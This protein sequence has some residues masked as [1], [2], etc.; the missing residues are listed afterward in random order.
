MLSYRLKYANSHFVDNEGLMVNEGDF[1]LAKHV[2]SS[3]DAV[4]VGVCSSSDYYDLMFESDTEFFSCTL[5]KKKFLQSGFS[6]FAFESSLE[7]TS[8]G[9]DPFASSKIFELILLRN[10]TVGSGG[11]E[12]PSNGVLFESLN[13]ADGSYADG[14]P[15]TVIGRDGAYKV[16]ASRNYYYDAKEKQNMLFYLLERTDLAH[17][18]TMLVADVHVQKVV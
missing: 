18:P 15:V 13:G 16:L 11:G 5:D 1:Y 12:T 4:V 3:G 9:F 14:T 7:F 10:S 6:F 17:K 8:F 2:D